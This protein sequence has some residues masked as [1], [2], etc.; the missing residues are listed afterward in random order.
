MDICASLTSERFCQCSLDCC[1]HPVWD[2]LIPVRKVGTLDWLTGAAECSFLLL[3]LVC[4]RNDRV[5]AYSLNE[6]CLLLTVG[7]FGL[8]N[9][10]LP[11]SSS[12]LCMGSLG[13]Q[14][15]NRRKDPVKL[16]RL[17]GY[18]LSGKN[19]P[20]SLKPRKIQ[21]NEKVRG[22]LFYLQLEL[23]YLQLSFFAYNP[24]RCFL[25]TISQC[26][27]RSS[28]VIKKLEFWVQKLKL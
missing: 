14:S 16:C 20:Q 3:R 13:L 9:V 15:L 18:G 4:W 25:D 2:Q 28:T 17:C 21:S 27:Q 8:K 19:V 23:F 22:K 1:L 7:E 24:L 5:V 12:G 6:A 11:L 10:I 26:K